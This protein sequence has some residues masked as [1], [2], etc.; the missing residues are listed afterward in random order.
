[1]AKRGVSVNTV[2]LADGKLDP[3]V[4]DRSI[5]RRT[6][7]FCASWVFSFSGVK[8]DLPTIKEVCR[9]RGVII[10]LNCSQALGGIP[11]DI[12]D[13]YA[14]ALTCV[15]FKWLCGPYGT[16]FCWI[17]PELRESLNYNQAYW[18]A[19]QTADDLKGPQDM[20]TIRDD[21]GARKYDVFG[22]ANF[23]N[24]KPWTE[25]V[26]LL[27]GFGVNDIWEYDQSLVQRLVDGL[28]KESF[29]IISPVQQG[30]GSNILVLSH[31]NS[32]HNERLFEMLERQRI[33]VSLRNG[34]LRFSPHLYNTEEQIDRALAILNDHL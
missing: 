6:R 20:P 30:E 23:F 26:N 1:L 32:A 2:E 24:F 25:A 15:G 12:R 22:T 9:R 27:L 18:L 3:D 29:E 33:H 13:G 19:M 16:G 14:D 21:I 11:F 31:R 8:L 5:G 28:D 10:V 17:E 4:L 34:R 7:V